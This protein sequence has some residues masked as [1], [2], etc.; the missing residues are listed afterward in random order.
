MTIRFLCPMGHPLA[1]PD[2][3]A[4]K[5]GRCPVCR[6]RVIVPRPAG[7]ASIS[8]DEV[9]NLLSE[10][11]MDDDDEDEDDSS[12]AAGQIE[13]E[14]EPTHPQRSR[15]KTSAEP[16]GGHATAPSAAG[17]RAAAARAARAKRAAAQASGPDS[18]PAAASPSDP[19]GEPHRRLGALVGDWDFRLKISLEPGG[20]PANSIGTDPVT[21][22][23]RRTAA[24]TKIRRPD[25]S[26]PDTS[27]LVLIPH[28]DS[29]FLW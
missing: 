28:Y 29:H 8:D 4:G 9:A 18:A 6:Q 20:T 1:V 5:K 24:Q 10:Q 13:A 7:G 11:S 2:N 3:R 22:N 14:E 12:V 19:P 17:A 16:G 25:K 15:T 23:E 27:K 26:V 21:E